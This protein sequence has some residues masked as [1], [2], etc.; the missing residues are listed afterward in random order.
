MRQ[1]YHIALGSN[2]GDRERNLRLAWERLQH[3]GSELLLS[4]L[5]ETEPMYLADQPYFLNAVGRMY[6]FLAPQEMLQA[7]HTI[8]DELGRDRGRE[9][10]MGPRSIDLDILLC[11]DLVMDEST[12]TIPH[13]RMTER[14]FVLIPLVEI[15]PHIRSPYG[16]PLRG[17]PA[18]QSPGC[19]LL[20]PPVV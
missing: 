7:L 2:L 13:P 15:S 11:G 12:L 6:S 17:P 18:R 20:S 14:G 5:Y 8:E 9:I 19:L 4:S 10:R 16:N 1:L 3:H